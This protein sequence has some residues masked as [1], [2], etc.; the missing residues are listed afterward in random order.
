M[1][2]MIEIFQIVLNAVTHIYYIQIFF[3]H[4]YGFTVFKRVQHL[5]NRNIL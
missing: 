1:N 5:Y 4:N 2:K 3:L